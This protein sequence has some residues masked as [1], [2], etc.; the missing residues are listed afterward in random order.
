MPLNCYQK[1]RRP[2]FRGFVGDFSRHNLHL[3]LREKVLYQLRQFCHPLR[4]PVAPRTVT[5]TQRTMQ[6][7]CAPALTAS[8][9]SAA[10]PLFSLLQLHTPSD[11]PGRVCMWRKQ[12]VHGTRGW[13]WRTDSEQGE[14]A[15]GGG[16]WVGPHLELPGQLCLWREIVDHRRKSRSRSQIP[17]IPHPT[18]QHAGPGQV[19]ANI[20]LPEA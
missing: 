7:M 4:P 5:R 18:S 10:E 3:A 17:H 19:Q 12:G 13:S 6:Y 15:I 1:G 16:E 20:Q 14:R 9:C 11:K 8:L 2:L